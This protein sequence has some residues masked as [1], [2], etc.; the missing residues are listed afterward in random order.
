MTSAPHSQLVDRIR[1]IAVVTT[2]ILCTFGVQ[3]AAVAQGVTLDAALDEALKSNEDY[4]IV[5]ARIRRSAALRREALAGLLPQLSAQGNLTMNAEEVQFGDNDPVVPRFDWGASARASIVLFDGSLYPGYSAAKRVEESRFEEGKWVRHG[6][7][8]EVE[9][10]FFSLI[11]AQSELEVAER[12]IELRSAY[13]ERAD[14]LAKQGIALPLDAARARTQLLEAQQGKIVATARLQNAA[15][16]LAVL[17]GRTT[18]GTLRASSSETM[19]SAPPG[20]V[21]QQYR[22]DLAAEGLLIEAVESR[23]SAV[24][25]SLAP[26]LELVGNARFGPASFSAPDGVA[27]SISLQLSWLLYDGGARYARAEALNAEADEL[28]WALKRLKRDATAEQTRTLR[29]WKAAYEAIALAEEKLKVAGEAYEL[30]SGRFEAGLATSIEVTQ[31]SDDLVNAELD[32]VTARL[33]ADLAKSSHAYVV[34]VPK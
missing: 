26:A 20:S 16:S 4:Q 33:G 6:L 30:A 32:L 29:N 9:Q 27:A 10:A 23:E 14:A 31:A 7:K 2:C 28:D 34:G 21:A 24:W 1:Q 17:L 12:T 8:Y 18:D 11:A 3:T 13:Y 19:R 25:W 22:P 15:D 5:E